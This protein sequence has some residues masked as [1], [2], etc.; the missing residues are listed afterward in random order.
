MLA[1][2]D[3]S[4]QHFWFIII[5]V[6]ILYLKVNV[7][8]EHLILIPVI[9][10]YTLKYVPCFHHFAYTIFLKEFVKYNHSGHYV[11]PAISRDFPMITI[12]IPQKC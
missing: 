9:I 7:I 5:S 10:L 8:K 11:G 3:T 12:M 4:S 1:C 2:K 6:C